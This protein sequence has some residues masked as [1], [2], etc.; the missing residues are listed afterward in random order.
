MK[1]KTRSISLL[2]FVFLLMATTLLGQNSTTVKERKIVSVT[3]QE[4]FI[5]EGLDEPEV[6]SFK[7]FN[8]K[9]E[10]TELKEFNNKGDI[11]RW[12]KYAYT[13][14]GRIEEEIFL[15]A[16]GKVDRREKSSYKDGLRIEKLYFNNKDKLYKKKVYEYE[17]RD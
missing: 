9:G 15:N 10:L 1:I 14:E 11:K 8:E 6:E 2:S 4:Y 16:K 5:E 3:V 17:Y 7:A 13:E 12:E